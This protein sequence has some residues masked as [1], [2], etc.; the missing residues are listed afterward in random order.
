MVSLCLSTPFSVYQVCHAAVGLVG[1]ICRAL[2]KV[3]APFCDEIMTILLENL[4]NNEV[5]ICEKHVLGV[6]SL[7]LGQIFWLMPYNLAQH[8]RASESADALKS[9]LF[10]AFHGK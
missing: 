8:S 1:D 4:S 3:V 9:R 7:V 5:T 6:I 10:K 2:G